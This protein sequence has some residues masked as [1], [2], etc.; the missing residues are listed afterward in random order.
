MTE[1]VPFSQCVSLKASRTE[2]DIAT[3]TIVIKNKLLHSGRGHWHRLGFLK[4]M[5]AGKLCEER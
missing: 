3:D 1:Q 4:I 2:T 5:Q